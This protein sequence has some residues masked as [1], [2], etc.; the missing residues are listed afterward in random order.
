MDHD[1]GDPSRGLA[2]RHAGGNGHRDD[3]VHLERHQ[4]AC[5]SRQAIQ[6]ASGVTL[7]N[8]DGLAVDVPQLTQ[9]IQKRRPPL[10]VTG[11]LLR[12]RPK[13][14]DPSHSMLGLLR[15]RGERPRRRATQNAE[16]IASPHIRHQVREPAAY[17]LNPDFDR[18]ETGL[19]RPSP[20]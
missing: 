11:Y 8:L 6:Y 7:V 20:G 15:A 10:Y 19:T 17:R 5:K 18:A 4:L 3:H 1:N 2:R 12:A 13:H 16:K 14:S 9:A